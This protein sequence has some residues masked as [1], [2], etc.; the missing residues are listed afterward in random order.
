[1]ADRSEKAQ[2]LVASIYKAVYGLNKLFDGRRFTPDGILV[3]SL[4]EVMAE[5]KYEIELL[6]PNSAKHDAIELKTNRQVQIKTNQGDSAYL[7]E[8]PDYFIA[9]KLLP[10][11][12]VKEIYN[13]PGRAAWQLALEVE[14]GKNGYH[15]IRH[16]K[17]INAM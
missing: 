16:S 17:L 3:G 2:E 8:E 5:I 6:R 1:M 14:K 4:G 12:Q 9:L 10:D 13:G 7:S 11:G 15:A